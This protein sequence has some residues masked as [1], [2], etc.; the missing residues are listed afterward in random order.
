M[1]R[2]DVLRLLTAG[3]TVAAG[4]LPAQ[5]SP[6]GGLWRAERVV[7]E[8]RRPGSP[9]SGKVLAAIQPH[10]DDIPLFAAGTVAKLIDEGCTGYLIRTTNDEKAGPGTMGDTV[11]GNER[12][13][14][15]VARV[16]G[17]R[18]V[19]DLN[20]RNHRLDDASRQDLRGRLIFLFR[21]LKVDIIVS[22]DPWGMYEENPDHYV[23]A[24]AV[25]AACWMAGGRKD[26]PEH[27]EAGVNPHSVSEKYYFAR[28]PQ[29]VNRV[30]DITS[31]IDKKIEANLV[32]VSQGPAGLAGSR[33]RTALAA[34]KLRLPALGSSDD[35]A[36]RE[37]VRHLVLD[38]DSEALRGVPS[39]RVAGRAF[40][41]EWAEP[42][43]YIGPRASRRET[44][45]SE[46]AQPLP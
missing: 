13:N 28:G 16:L 19:F 30:V 38:V 26:Y 33:L 15:A 45:I 31:V 27:V 41:F 23:T 24:Q 39:D 17:L 1:N 18:K 32:N 20:Y 43:H 10:S 4:A 8:P 35:E 5:Q 9:R 2:R 46:H 37:Y 11:L 36:N 40:G 25:E 3:G 44:Y 42:F 22:Y 7:A 6:D 21:L 12:D 29:L 14:Q 34:K